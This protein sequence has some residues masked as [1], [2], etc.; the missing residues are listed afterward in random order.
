[1]Q[2]SVFVFFA[3]PSFLLLLL[4]SFLFSHGDAVFP[5]YECH[6]LI[7]RV[8]PYARSSHSKTHRDPTCFHRIAHVDE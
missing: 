2:T 5:P 6:H 7:Y 1:M 3:S 8:I 4:F